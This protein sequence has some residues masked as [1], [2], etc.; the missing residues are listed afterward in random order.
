MVFIIFHLLRSYNYFITLY[1]TYVVY[2]H[3]LIICIINNIII[4]KK[5][6]IYMSNL[7]I[8]SWLNIFLFLYIFHSSIHF[9]QLLT[10]M[11]YFPSPPT[12]PTMNSDK[13]MCGSCEQALDSVWYCANCHTKCNTCNR[14]LS[15]YEYCTRCW[16]FDT[17]TNQYIR[18]NQHHH[19]FYSSNNSSSSSLPL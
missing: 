13:A 10:I 5:K 7:N 4:E 11:N 1:I 3:F 12:S 8:N 14:F 18:K 16:T 2:F 9:Q 15:Q 17:C 6:C 19:H